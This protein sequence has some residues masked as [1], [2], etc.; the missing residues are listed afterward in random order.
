[1]SVSNLRDLARRAADAQHDINSRTAV[2]RVLEEMAKEISALRKEVD[3]LK[4]KKE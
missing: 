2:Y 4:E 3:E 1:M